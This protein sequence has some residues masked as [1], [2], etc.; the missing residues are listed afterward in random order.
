V[1]HRG[2]DV[3]AH[4]LAAGRIE[5]EIP[6]GADAGLQE[7]AREPLEQQSP[8]PAVTPILEW[9]IKQIVERRNA[10]ITL[11]GRK[12]DWPLRIQHKG[13]WFVTPSV[14]LSVAFGVGNV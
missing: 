9:E 13:R 1:Q 8:D 4:D 10:L 2:A 11:V 14:A 3:D 5:W 6:A 7:P 12:H